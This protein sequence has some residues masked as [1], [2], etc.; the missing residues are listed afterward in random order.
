[1]ARLE[2]LYR[3]EVHVG[4][5]VGAIGGAPGGSG[6]IS[7]GNPAAQLG[8]LTPPA[9]AVAWD[10]DVTEL[11]TATFGP[12]CLYEARGE[13]RAWSTHAAAAAILATG[14]AAVDETALPELL[15]AEF[16]GGAR[17]LVRGVTALAPGARVRIDVDGV[18]HEPG[19][20]LA[21]RWAPVE[22]P[23]RAAETALVESLGR[24]LEAAAAPALGLTGGLDSR[25]AAVALREAG[26]PFR[27]FTWGQ[28]DWPDADPARRVAAALGVDHEFVGLDL[29]PDDEALREARRA[30]AWTDGSALL[31]IGRV[32]WPAEIGAFVTGGAGEIGRAF[33]YRLAARNYRRPR[34]RQL[35]RLL[36]A[37]LHARLGSDAAE[38]RRAIADAAD[39]WVAEAAGAGI[40][41]W[42]ILDVVYAE[43]RVRRWGR[44]MMPERAVALVPAFGVPEVARALASLPLEERVADGFHRRF[45]ARLA[46]ELA[47]A[48][49]GAGQRALV[50]AFARRAAAAARRRR[51]MPAAR[52]ALAGEWASRPGFRTWV[53][54]EVLA[55]APYRELL[56]AGWCERTREEF[57]AGSARGERLA[58]LAAGPVALAGA[59]AEG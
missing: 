55:W 46:P 8:G 39:A 27:A 10:A 23:Q 4:A 58:L 41:G 25:V 13:L 45:L 18:R 49:P 32:R 22:D 14:G 54:D 38:A 37:D 24:R 44:A 42:R 15:A 52:G 11:A 5:A 16:T 21:E 9:A 47:P 19:P 12:A 28:P 20:P 59:L 30:A 2:R 57:L 33:Y 26:V 3:D 7:F 31:A 34:P 43:Q 40:G 29:L 48:A 6:L 1:M 36:A 35:A 50:P 53:A 56:G 51:G 17:S